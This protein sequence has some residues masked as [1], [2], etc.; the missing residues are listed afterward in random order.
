[1]L[2]LS[3]GIQCL[4]IQFNASKSLFF[5]CQEIQQLSERWIKVIE[6]NRYMITL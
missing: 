3:A 2:L 6:N 4:N 5:C 1:M